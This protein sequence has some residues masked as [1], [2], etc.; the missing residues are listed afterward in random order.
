M[1][2]QLPPPPG[3]T[4]E[5]V[6]RCR[7]SMD[8]LGDVEDARYRDLILMHVG[9][10]T[11]RA[12]RD[13]SENPSLSALLA[14]QLLAGFDRMAS[15]DA[16]KRE[17]L[18]LAAVYFVLIDDDTNDFDDTHGLEDDAKVVAAVLRDIGLS[19]LAKPIDARLAADQG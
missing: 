14:R 5:Q 10:Q 2:T 4:A 6:S 3:M 9:D 18:K 16:T 1:S 11:R 12:V 7:A 13:V 19:E 17:W 15:L 8:A